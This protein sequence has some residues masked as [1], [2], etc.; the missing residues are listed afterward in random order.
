MINLRD[1]SPDTGYICRRILGS[2]YQT[3]RDAPDTSKANESSAGQGSG[4]LATDVIGL[5]RHGRRDICIRSGRCEEHPG[6]AEG[7]A[8]AESH[9]GQPDERNERVECNDGCADTVFIRDV[10]RG[11]HYYGGEGVGRRN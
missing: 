1:C 5:I 6:V 11:V 2:K 8:L 7:A 4:P 9:H 3:A 10:G